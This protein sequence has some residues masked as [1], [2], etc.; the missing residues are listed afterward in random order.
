MEQCTRSKWLCGVDGDK[1]DTS[2]KRRRTSQQEERVV[3][4]HCEGSPIDR[5]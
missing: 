2:S 3:H 4:I 5:M 1:R